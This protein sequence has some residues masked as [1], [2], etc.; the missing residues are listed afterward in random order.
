MPASFF[1]CGH[2]KCTTC[3]PID[4]V[5]Y[6]VNLITLGVKKLFRIRSGFEF[7]DS[8][9]KLLL[10]MSGDIR[11]LTEGVLQLVIDNKKMLWSIVLLI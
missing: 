11:N 6:F 9:V 3:I 8:L 5:Q 7:W 4:T 2:I 1:S 10:V